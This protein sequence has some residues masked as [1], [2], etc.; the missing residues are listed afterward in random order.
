MKRNGWITGLLLLAL[1]LASGCNSDKNTTMGATETDEGAVEELAASEEIDLLYDAMVNDG[2]EDNMYDG[3]ST[4]GGG[5]GK[6]SA[7]IENVLRFGRRFE[8]F[9]RRAIRDIRRIS[10]DTILVTTH[11]VFGGAFVIFAKGDD[12]GG[13]DPI[14]LHRKRI[15]HLVNRKAIFVRNGQSDIVSDVARNGWRLDAVSLGY[16]QSN[17]ETTID[18]HELT[19]SS[20]HGVNV[21]FTDPLHTFYNTREE[22]PTFVPNEVVT[23]RVAL[24]NTTL[25]PVDPDGT[26][27]TERVLLHFGVN[28]EH[29]ARK[30]LDFVQVDPVT[31][32]HIYEGTWTIH[33]RPGH[34]YHAAI[35]VIDNGTIYDTDVDTYPY[36]STVWS[37]P[38]RVQESK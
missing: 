28:R 33:Q 11:R 12:T 25:N 38:Y 4:F 16:G 30:Q 35:D 18:I 20:D 23:V 3:Y 9:P 32:L 31:G 10:R 24:D 2:S 21:T 7:P 1:I 13:T 6:V 8:P 14:V 34:A 36:N 17:P 37:T 29:H 19:I 22:L 15:N 5:F 27:A 26:G